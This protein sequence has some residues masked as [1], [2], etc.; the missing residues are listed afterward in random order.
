MP[1]RSRARRAAVVAMTT[2]IAS[3]TRAIARVLLVATCFVAL[4]TTDAAAAA[5]PTPTPRTCVSHDGLPEFAIAGK[6][7]A[8]NRGLTFCADYGKST[9]CDK[10]TTDAIRRVVAH[11]QANAFSPRCRDAWTSLEC[12][13]CDPRAG[14]TP[15]TAVCAH[16]CDAIYR[17]CKDEYFSEDSLRR[18]VPCRASDTICTKL[19]DWG[20][21]GGLRR[22]QPP[23]DAAARPSPQRRLLRRRLRVPRRRQHRRL[24]LERLRLPPVLVRSDREVLAKVRVSRGRRVRRRRRLEQPR[25]HARADGFGQARAVRDPRSRRRGR[26]VRRARGDASDRDQGLVVLVR[27]RELVPGL[28]VRRRRGRR[29][30]LTLHEPVLVLRLFVDEL[31]DAVLVADVA[32]AAGEAPHRDRSS[33]S[34]SGGGCISRFANHAASSGPG[35]GLGSSAEGSRRRV[36]AAW[37]RVTMRARVSRAGRHLRRGECPGHGGRAILKRESW[38]R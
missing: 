7:P 5:T 1:Q 34:S 20:G 4:A 33:S 30:E 36:R 31:V 9:C 32:F 15:R 10:G 29:V 12:S 37:T 3:S 26:V 27:T 25:A 28:F 24:R 38:S 13:V 2:T 35:A 21:D 22:R 23:R 16:A 11:M 19:S 8:K 14:T 18:L 6:P 17:A